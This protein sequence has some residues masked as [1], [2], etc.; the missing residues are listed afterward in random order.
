LDVLLYELNDIGVNIICN[1]HVNNIIKKGNSFKIHLKDKP[2]IQCDSVIIATG[3]KA[4]PS[5]GS[6]GNGFELAKKLGHSVIDIF[7]AL[8]QLKLEVAFFDQIQG[9]K[10]V[11]TAELLHEDKPLAKD[12]GDI[13]FANYGISGPPILQISRRA[14]KL[15]QMGENAIL[16]ITI[17]DTMS[18]DE[19]RQYMM[20]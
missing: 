10:F 16:K 14:G 17:I 4:M 11:G 12:R 3:G 2:P 15:L 13:L 1:A 20:Q 8:V 19:L 6:D 9:V 7:P 5:T 18:K